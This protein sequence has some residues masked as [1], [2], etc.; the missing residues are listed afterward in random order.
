MAV[1]ETFLP[2]NV[3]QNMKLLNPY[4]YAFFLPDEKVGIEK[5]SGEGYELITD[6]YMV[7]PEPG[8]YRFYRE[9]PSQK[10]SFRC[11]D[12]AG[13]EVDDLLS[14]PPGCYIINNEQFALDV[15]K[16]LQRQGYIATDKF[17]NSFDKGNKAK[18]YRMLARL[19][20]NP[21]EQQ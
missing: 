19:Y 6:L 18:V 7:Q 13:T 16:E 10:T 9:T 17:Y 4:D 5:T 21:P 3:L 12:Y 11:R 14:E 2:Y 15:V 20:E 1:V 8:V